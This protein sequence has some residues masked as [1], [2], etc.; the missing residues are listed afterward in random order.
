ML[1]LSDEL[2]PNEAQTMPPL[3]DH[4]GQALVPISTVTWNT[5]ASRGGRDFNIRACFSPQR[6]LP[7]V[8]DAQSGTPTNAGRRRGWML[9]HTNPKHQSLRGCAHVCEEK[10]TRDRAVNHLVQFLSEPA[11]RVLSDDLELAKLRKGISYCFWMSD[12]LLVQQ[13][14]ASELA[15]IFPKIPDPSLRSF[16]KAAVLVGV[17]ARTIALFGF[18]R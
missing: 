6:P 1:S 14:L 8:F 10:A 3:Q 15:D 4:F 11:R 5:F 12:K 16:D 18:P 7:S 13:A 9:K 17:A 2:R